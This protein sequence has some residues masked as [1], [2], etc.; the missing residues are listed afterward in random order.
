MGSVLYNI[1]F[2]L[3]FL[4]IDNNIDIGNFEQPNSQ[5][6]NMGLIEYEKLN[7]M[8]FVKNKKLTIIDYSLSSKEKRLWV[9]D[10]EKKKVIF[11]TWVAHGKNSGDECAVEFSNTLQSYKTSLGVFLTN[12]TYLGKHGLSLRLDGMNK[13][14]NSNARK[15]NIVMHCSDYVNINTINEIGYIGK[16]H[17]CLAISK[18]VNKELINMV[19]N[20]SVIFSYHES[21]NN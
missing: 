12:E 8:G 21:L 3:S 19:K 4:S 10:M 7:K 15:R 14:L 13:G 17:G 18:D 6:I 11:Q 16:S 2:L 5:M 9:I 1:Y 20:S